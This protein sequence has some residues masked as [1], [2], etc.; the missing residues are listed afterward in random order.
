MDLLGEIEIRIRP[1]GYVTFSA[2]PEALLEVAAAIN[3]NDP[4]ILRR[5][6]I[7]RRSAK[8]DETALAPIRADL[9]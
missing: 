7:L 4:N 3:P 2:L 9:Q 6:E 1:D 8:T 5:L